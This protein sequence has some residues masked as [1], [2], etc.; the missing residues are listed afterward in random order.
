MHE[1]VENQIISYHKMKIKGKRL[2]NRSVQS[3]RKVSFSLVVLK[4][5]N[6]GKMERTKSW[7][8]GVNVHVIKFLP[9]SVSSPLSHRI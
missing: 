1:I 3:L 4:R 9:R 5:K 7:T 8:E 2:F 6:V